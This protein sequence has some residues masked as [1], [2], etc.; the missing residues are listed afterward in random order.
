MSN[1]E[2]MP[3]YRISRPTLGTLFK[4]WYRPKI[5]GR[6]N[7]PKEGPI[8]LVGNHVNIMDQCNV[9]VSTKRC[10]HYMA[11]KEYFDPKYKEGK[12]P[13]FFKGAGCIPVD[14]SKKDDEAISAALEVLRDG[15]ALGLFPEGTRNALKEN[16]IKDYYKKY[17][18]EEN[19]KSFYKKMKENKAS[20]IYYLEELKDKKVISKKEFIKSLDN[21]KEYLQKLVNEKRIEKEDYYNHYLLPLKF[22]AVSMAKKTDALLVPYAITGDYRFL[23]KNLKVRIGKPFK[24]DDDLEKAN[25]KLDR[26]IKKL[27][28]ENENKW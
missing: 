24:V 5:I 14:R 13:W 23:G 6:D 22:G 25:N 19:Y 3:I 17:K 8:I 28:K 26:E 9:I 11:K 4:L 15:Y 2:K 20:F 10:I 21:V 12:F 7:I 18:I 27:V 16:I 1:K